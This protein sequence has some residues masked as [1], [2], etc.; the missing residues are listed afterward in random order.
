VPILL[1]L[2]AALGLFTIA[3]PAAGQSGR[4]IV[5]LRAPVI[6]GGSV[7]VG[8]VVALLAE[9]KDAFAPGGISP[10]VAFKVRLVGT[11]DAGTPNFTGIFLTPVLGARPG[12]FLEFS[13]DKIQNVDP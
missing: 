10:P 11:P 4:V 12:E 8:N 1:G 13:Q 6:F 9:H 3:K 5:L 7:N 2:L